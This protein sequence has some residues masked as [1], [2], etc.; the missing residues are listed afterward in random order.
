MDEKGRQCLT[1]TVK[2]IQKSI[3]RS[4][5]STTGLRYHAV[6]KPSLDT[7]PAGNVPHLVFPLTSSQV[8]YAVT[9]GHHERCMSLRYRKNRGGRDT[10]QHPSRDFA[11][12]FRTVVRTLGAS[13]QKYMY[14]SIAARTPNR[15]TV[16]QSRTT[17]YPR[18]IH[19]K[20]IHGV[21][22][23]KCVVNGA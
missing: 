1:R 23:K 21:E 13:V 18:Q 5:H 11:L 15:I 6:L 2:R 7:Q 19:K 16:Q 4:D 8:I 9:P 17:Q 20:N 22:G 14:D 3:H 10:C 12:N